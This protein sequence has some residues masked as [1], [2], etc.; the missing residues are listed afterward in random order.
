MEDLG[1]YHACLASVAA[2]RKHIGKVKAPPLEDSRKWM[3]SV[4]EAGYPFLVVTDG[5]AVVGWCDVGRRDGEGFRHT[6]ELG[7]GLRAETRRRGLGSQLLQRAIELSRRC[8]VEKVELQVYA[9]NTAARGL[10]ESFG[11]VVEGTRV[12]ARKLDGKYDDVVLMGLFL[13]ANP[14]VER[15]ARKSGARPSP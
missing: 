10:Y 12:Q 7:M 1:G 15:D 9:S 11:F 4:I 5:S 2:E 8:G 6:A 14:T 3:K 13:T